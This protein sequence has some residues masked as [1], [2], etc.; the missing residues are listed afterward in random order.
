MSTA[1]SKVEGKAKHCLLRAGPTA[2][3]QQG[4]PCGAAKMPSVCRS[5]FLSSLRHSPPQPILV[6]RRTSLRPSEGGN[7]LLRSGAAMALA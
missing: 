3:Q 6:L 7:L 1:R 2:G 5:P 4:P